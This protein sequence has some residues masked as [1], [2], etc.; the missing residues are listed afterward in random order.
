MATG[1]V[2][3]KISV[4]DLAQTPPSTDYDG[5]ES[6]V[7]LGRSPTSFTFNED[8]SVILRDALK[9]L[10]D[11]D[12]QKSKEKEREE[13]KWFVPGV[14]KEKEVEEIKTENDVSSVSH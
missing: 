3:E 10:S 14:D 9:S 12:E 13:A 6:F 5:E 2:S 7:V 8:A 4:G 11:A 1:G